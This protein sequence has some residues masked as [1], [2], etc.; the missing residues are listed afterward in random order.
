MVRDGYYYGAGLIAAAIL[1]GWLTYPILA[2]L[3]ILLA[4][5]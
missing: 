2:V 3:P 5:F 4:A 1:I